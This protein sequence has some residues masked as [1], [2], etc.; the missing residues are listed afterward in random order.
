MIHQVL[1]SRSNFN[2]NAYIYERADWSS[3]FHRNFEL[4]Y[5][6][7]GQNVINVNKLNIVLNP[8]ELLLI[9]PGI[10]HSFSVENGKKLWVA[11]FSADFIPSFARTN[12]NKFYS[13]FKCDNFVEEYLK[14]AL[15]FQGEPKKYI[16]KSALY[17]ACGQCLQ[18][19]EL[20][21]ENLNEK[22]T[23]KILEYIHQNSA[24]PLT[25]KDVASDLGLEYHYFSSIFHQCFS[26][27]FRELLNIYRFETACQLL[28]KTDRKLSDI[29]YASG[30][31]SIRNFNT[32]FKKLSG[33]TPN[34]Y[35]KKL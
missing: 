24:K 2:Y 3:H 11:V 21:T 16:L 4:I 33:L 12:S 28:E 32:A 30:F 1:N 13:K 20:L 35:R 29:A 17:A 31:Q 25:M 34:E 7:K 6:I 23:N 22:I 19:A 9:P 14:T 5:G 8:G 18:H 26:M 15:F 27:N 10:V